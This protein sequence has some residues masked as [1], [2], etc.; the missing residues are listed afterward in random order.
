MDWIVGSRVWG[1]FLAAEFVFLPAIFYLRCST[2]SARSSVD[3]MCRQT[4]EAVA[5]GERRRTPD[6]RA[7]TAR[8]VVWAVPPTSRPP[9]RS[10]HIPVRADRVDQRAQGCVFPSPPHPYFFFQPH[11]FQHTAPPTPQHPNNTHCQCICSHTRLHSRLKLGTSQNKNTHTTRPSPT[12]TQHT[13]TPLHMS[14]CG[15][16]RPPHGLSRAQKPPANTECV[17]PPPPPPAAP[18]AHSGRLTPF[19]P[20]TGCGH[21]PPRDGGNP[22]RPGRQPDCRARVWGMR[23]HRPRHG[24][25]PGGVGVHRV[26]DGG[27]GEERERERGKGRRMVWWCARNARAAAGAPIGTDNCRPNGRR[28][29]R[30]WRRGRWGEAWAQ[31]ESRGAVTLERGVRIATATRATLS[32]LS[33]R[34]GFLACFLG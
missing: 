16:Q 28:A 17:T 6:T 14:T 21:S 22:T 2:S 19:T 7:K 18:P 24:G 31:R 10:R 8:A 13:H 23:V 26:L 11:T 32:P 15:V 5:A 34:V 33:P 1:G 25:L 29:V 12:R 3:T 20:G 27:P 9:A 4:R 30:V